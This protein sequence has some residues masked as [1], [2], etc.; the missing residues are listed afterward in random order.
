[1]TGG[2]QAWLLPQFGRV[3]MVPLHYGAVRNAI[4]IEDATPEHWMEALEVIAT[5]EQ[6]WYTGFTDTYLKLCDKSW[7]FWFKTFLTRGRTLTA[8]INHC[9]AETHDRRQ[10][11]LDTHAHKLSCRGVNWGHIR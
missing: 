6:C 8:F 3:V 1:M 4:K 2:K 10:K 5:L 7:W 11:A 9:S